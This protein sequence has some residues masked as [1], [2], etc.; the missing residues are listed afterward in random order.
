MSRS[1]GPPTAMVLAPPVVTG[2]RAAEQNRTA[3]RTRQRRAR[4]EPQNRRLP[5]PGLNRDLGG[6]AER[7]AADDL[8]RRDGR[9]ADQLQIAVVVGNRRIIRDTVAE[10]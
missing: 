3:R 7:Q 6:N 9:I 2:V 4:V 10:M 1:P 8:F 5:G